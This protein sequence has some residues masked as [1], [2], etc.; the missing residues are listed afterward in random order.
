MRLTENFTLDEFRCRCGCGE[1]IEDNAR[2]L[3]VLLQDLRDK[4]G[5]IEILSGHRCA[6]HNETVGG[7]RGSYHLQSKAADLGVKIPLWVAVYAVDRLGVF[8][9]VGVGET[10]LHVDIGPR[11]WWIYK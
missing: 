6:S 10:R 1:V 2:R 8:G 7:S 11:R 9:G 4:I 3:A 5:P